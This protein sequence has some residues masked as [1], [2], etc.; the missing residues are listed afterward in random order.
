[1]KWIAHMDNEP[2]TP[3]AR[4]A[5]QL[6]PHVANPEWPH[7]GRDALDH[8]HAVFAIS[9]HLRTLGLEHWLPRLMRWLSHY[10][11]FERYVEDGHDPCV[12]VRDLLASYVTRFR[13]LQSP[14]LIR[15]L[16]CHP[17]E[18]LKSVVNDILRLDIVY[19]R[20][21]WGRGLY[22]DQDSRAWNPLNQSWLSFI[23]SGRPGEELFSWRAHVPPKPTL[24]QHRTVLLG[25]HDG[26]T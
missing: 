20:A 16:A 18:L 26:S 1:M 15:T 6:E 23:E 24:D 13:V 25:T 17:G 7:W 22:H 19:Y 5:S 8:G 9:A 4:L 11:G 2:F 21:Y 14:P 3:K 10:D 12:C